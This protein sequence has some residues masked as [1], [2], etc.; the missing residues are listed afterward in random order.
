MALAGFGPAVMARS[1][2]S[3][4]AARDACFLVEHYAPSYLDTAAL[5]SREEVVIGAP[6]LTDLRR[7]QTA[8]PLHTPFFRD[9]LGDE[10]RFFLPP[11]L[12]LDYDQIVRDEIQAGFRVLLQGRSSTAS[13]AGQWAKVF[14]AVRRRLGKV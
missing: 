11:Y 2:E 5:A 8:D 13:V 14:T 6:M 3:E 1:R 12:L 4:L 9:T 10:R 7:P